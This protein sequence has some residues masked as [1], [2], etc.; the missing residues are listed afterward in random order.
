MVRPT[1]AP[2]KASIPARNIASRVAW[3][4]VG[5]IALILG[6]AGAVL[7]ILPTTPFVILAAFAFG[8]G[9]PA[10]QVWLERHALFGPIIADWQANGAIAPKYKAIALVAMAFSVALSFAIAV[11][12]V[13]VAVQVIC[14]MGA[15]LFI[16]SR[17]S[18]GP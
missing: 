18:R 13:V 1:P 5:S 8:R 12:P 11:P 17:P 3:Q 6:L 2:S 4:I 15:A 10:V 14:I 9:A 16:L 7:P